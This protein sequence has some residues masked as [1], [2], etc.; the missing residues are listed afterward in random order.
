[1]K[2]HIHAPVEAHDLKEIIRQAGFKVTPGRLAILSIFSDDCGALCAEDIHQ[3]IGKKSL[4]YVTV[5]RTLE[6]FEQA[7]ILK[8]VFLQKQ[9]AYYERAGH[10]HHH[11]VCTHCG[12]VEQFDSCGVESLSKNILSESKQFKTIKDHSLEFFGVCKS[13]IA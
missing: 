2:K 12:I 10:H 7:R 6:S 13:C 9:A 4:D 5:Y 8:K 1:M 11:I 3:K